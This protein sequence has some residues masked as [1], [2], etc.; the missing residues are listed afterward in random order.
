[1]VRNGVQVVAMGGDKYDSASQTI[2]LSLEQNDMV[3][4]CH[5]KEATSTAHAGSDRYYTSFSGA[6]IT[7]L[8]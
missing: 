4:V 5:F 1:M 2:M 3:W 8:Q 7:A 6:L